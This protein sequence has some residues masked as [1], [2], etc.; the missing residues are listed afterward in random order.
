MRTQSSRHV[1]AGCNRQASLGQGASLLAGPGSGSVCRWWNPLVRL[2][3]GAVKHA[4]SWWDLLTLT[5]GGVFYTSPK[6]FVGT[7]GAFGDEFLGT[8]LLV[9]HD[10]GHR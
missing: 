7:F 6:A 8:A 2:P 3:G 5:V 9:W 1:R 4:I 10:P